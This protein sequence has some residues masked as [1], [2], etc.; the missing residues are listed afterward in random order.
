MIIPALPV[1]QKKM[2]HWDIQTTMRCVAMARKMTKAVENVYVP[3][4]LRQAY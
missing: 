1:R 3:E 2:K 4:F